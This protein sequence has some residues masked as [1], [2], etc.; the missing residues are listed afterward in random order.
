MA[1]AIFVSNRT[2][3][4]QPGGGVQWCT[5]DY[6]DTMAAAGIETRL[7]EYATDRGLDSRLRRRFLPRPFDNLV[8]ARLVAEVESARNETGASWICLNNSD[9]PVLAGAFAR[10]SKG[11]ARVVFLSHGVESVDQINQLRIDSLSV[12]RHR[13]QPR[14]IG[15]LFLAELEHRRHLDGVVCISNEDT[16]F[17]RWLGAARVCFL[18]RMIRSEPLAWQP[19]EGRVGTVATLNHLPNLDGIRRL[20]AGLNHHRGLRLRVVGR[21]EASGM[22]LAREFS[23]IDYLGELDDASMKAEAAT[24]CAFVNPIFCQARG[25]STKLATAL[26]WGLPV[27]TSVQGARGYV[28]N[29]ALLPRFDTVEDMADAVIQL[30]ANHEHEDWRKRASQLVGL[31]PTLEQSAES[32]KRFLASLESPARGAGS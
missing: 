25:A 28:W 8:P 31:A 10:A 16:L 5:R 24:W 17:E 4:A 19:Q 21:P 1:T 15:R 13:R 29:D 7:V 32:L 30:T 11:R 12:P 26:G 27:V 3:L 18:P 9:L 2:Y 22:R 20:A 23:C 14:W 6:L